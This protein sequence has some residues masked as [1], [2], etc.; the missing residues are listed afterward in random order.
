[1]R[2]AVVSV[3]ALVLAG[4]GDV[5]LTSAYRSQPVVVDGKYD[6]WE[7]NLKFI[8][9]INMSVGAMNDETNLYA[10]LVIGDRETQQQVLSGGLFLWFD[11]AGKSDRQF[12]IHYPLGMRGQR[13][14]GDGTDHRRGE[15]TDAAEREAMMAES[16]D[17]VELVGAGG[18]AR[19]TRGLDELPGLDVRSRHERGAL[20]VEYRIPLMADV[21][22][23]Y[24]VGAVPGQ[25]VGVGLVTPEWKRPQV[26]D[27]TTGRRRPPG[28]ADGDDDGDSGERPARNAGGGPGMRPGGGM[29]DAPEPINLWAQLRLAVVPP[30][31][32]SAAP[33]RASR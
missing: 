14:G 23:P 10:I 30:A 31:S 18:A 15:R 11:P 13:G 6:E 33:P 16:L 19:I 29:F 2:P 12:G 17:E 20:V 28:D 24:G 21:D 27:G 1:M 3:A 26:D 25:V 9:K 4:C 8:E 7:G 22:N 5:S 32:S